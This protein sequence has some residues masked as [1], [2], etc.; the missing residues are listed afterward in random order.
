MS[1]PPEELRPGRQDRPDRPGNPLRPGGPAGEQSWRW[2]LAVLGVLVVLGLVLS[3]FFNTAQRDE[4]T[5]S[6]LLAKVGE[7]GVKS[8]KVICSAAR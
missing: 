6:E 4:L 3:P 8:A 2:V 1:R 5:Y 7:G